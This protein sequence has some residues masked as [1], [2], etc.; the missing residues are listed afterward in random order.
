MKLFL[1]KCWLQLTLEPQ[2][3]MIRE[4]RKSTES[5]VQIG[6]SIGLQRITE[7]PMLFKRFRKYVTFSGCA[8]GWWNICWIWW[9]TTSMSIKITSLVWEC[10][11]WN[12]WMTVIW[13][14]PACNICLYV[15][16]VMSVKAIWCLWKHRRERDRFFSPRFLFPTEV[17]ISRECDCFSLGRAMNFLKHKMMISAAN[18]AVNLLICQ[19][20][21]WRFFQGSCCSSHFTLVSLQQLQTWYL[22]KRLH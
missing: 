6:L 20:K 5:L 15:L 13:E 7:V 17:R 16:S 11:A 2:V 22:S 10:P 21:F 18:L 12:I 19:Y 4:L 14:C 9:R 1:L 8:V 3:E